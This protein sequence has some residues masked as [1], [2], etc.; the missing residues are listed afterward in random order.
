[1]RKRRR[2]SEE[3]E[4]GKGHLV[5]LFFSAEWISKGQ[6]MREGRANSKQREK[7]MSKRA[8]KRKQQ[9]RA[10]GEEK[11]RRERMKRQR[12]REEKKKEKKK[13]NRE[14]REYLCRASYT[15]SR[16]YTDGQRTLRPPH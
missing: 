12:S 8:R 16:E 3:A 14:E 15:S 2:V 9:E 4:R 7:G 10:R 13:K 5:A 6:C 11:E 1:M